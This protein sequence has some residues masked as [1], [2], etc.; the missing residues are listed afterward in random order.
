[1]DYDG[2]PLAEVYDRGRTYPPGTLENWL[3]RIA[4]AAAGLRVRDILDVGCGTGRYT[5]PLAEHFDANAC[6]VDP[7]ATMLAHAQRRSTDQVRFCS[8]AA[9]SL[10]FA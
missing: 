9:E 10:P 7:S 4:D 8:A 1:M 6:G 3:T 5:C 2:T